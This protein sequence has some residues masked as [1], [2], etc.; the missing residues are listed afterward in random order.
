M[1]QC[2]TFILLLCVVVAVW[3]GHPPRFRRHTLYLPSGAAAPVDTNISKTA[4]LLYMNNT[5]S[6]EPVAINSAPIGID[7]DVNLGTGNEPP[8]IESSATGTN[9]H[10][11]FLGANDFLIVRDLTGLSSSQGVFDVWVNLDQ[12]GDRGRVI[13]MSNE[14]GDANHGTFFLEQTTADNAAMRIV[15]N[16]TVQWAAET[17]GGPLT[18]QIGEWHKW[19]VRH[20]G[21]FVQFYLDGVSQALN[22]FITTD[23]NAW[24]DVAIGSTDPPDYIAMGAGLFGGVANAL[25][26]QLYRGAYYNGDAVGDLLTPAEI[27]LLTNTSPVDGTEVLPE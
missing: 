14:D 26:A 12:T 4:F 2:L 18:A 15:V 7:W 19:T 20:N 5:N 25:N 16:G 22:F 9:D 11:D 27:L 3:A 1:K 10:Y 21:D 17:T 6:S 24:L 8:R 23:T 13:Q